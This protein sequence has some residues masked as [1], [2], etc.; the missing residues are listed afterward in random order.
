MLRRF[1]HDTA[2]SL[3]LCSE[4]PAVQSKYHVSAK[5]TFGKRVVRA[6]RLGSFPYAHAFHTQT[7]VGGQGVLQG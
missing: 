5:V 1:P 6:V 7:L 4:N 2:Y 3:P